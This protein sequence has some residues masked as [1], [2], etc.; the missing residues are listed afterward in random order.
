L[1]VGASPRQILQADLRGPI[2]LMCASAS[3]SL[4]SIYAAP[5]DRGQPYITAAIQ[6]LAGGI[7]FRSPE[8]RW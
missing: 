2:A 4:G 6:M 5:S 3:W 7:M 8:A 1:L